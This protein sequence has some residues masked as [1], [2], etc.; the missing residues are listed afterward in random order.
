MRHDSNIIHT[1][2][3]IRYSAR[4][5]HSSAY[6]QQIHCECALYNAH[7]FSWS[8]LWRGQNKE[9]KKERKMAM[10]SSSTQFTLPHKKYVMYLHI[11]YT[12]KYI[13][14]FLCTVISWWY[15]SMRFVS[16]CP[17][18]KTD[19]FGAFALCI[20]ICVTWYV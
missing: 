2:S 1:H 9:K 8:V 13:Y 6:W 7:I 12:Y 4:R 14:S 5:V 3:T 15:T 17:L 11:K 19:I 20:C 16:M 18:L 10:A